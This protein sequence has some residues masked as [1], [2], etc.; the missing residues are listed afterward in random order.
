MPVYRKRPMLVIADQF[1]SWSDP[2]TWPE[3]VTW[4]GDLPAG[5]GCY[6][7]TLPSGVKLPVADGDWIITRPDGKGCWA[8]EGDDFPRAYELYDPVLHGQL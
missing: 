5:T 8:V 3:A 7:V 2:D 6:V 1:H 4:G